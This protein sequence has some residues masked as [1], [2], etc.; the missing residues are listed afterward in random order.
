M[1]LPTSDGK[2]IESYRSLAAGA[3]RAMTRWVRVKAN[4]SLGAYEITEAASTIPDPTW[5]ECPFPE[6]LR[7][8]FRDRL[9]NSLDHPVIK[10]LLGQT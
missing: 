2:V 8:A 4:T 7:I 1:R 10:R 3:E 6:L 9:V 5:P